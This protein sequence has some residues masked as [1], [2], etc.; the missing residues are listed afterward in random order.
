MIDS[1]RTILTWIRWVIAP[2]RKTVSN[3][4]MDNGECPSCPKCGCAT[5]RSRQDLSFEISGGEI[6]TEPLVSATI[7][8]N[9]PIFQCINPSCRNGMYGEEAEKIMEPIKKVLTK[10]AV[11]KS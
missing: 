7:V 2:T 9:V 1:V 5:I 4:Q 8:M 6:R 10:H 3:S 11:V